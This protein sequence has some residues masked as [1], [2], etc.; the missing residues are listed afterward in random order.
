M[1]DIKQIRAHIASLI[2]MREHVPANHPFHADIASAIWSL[3]NID[4]AYD[5]VVEMRIIE[6]ILEDE[7]VV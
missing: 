5:A 1:L 4:K 3:R 7:E 2:E 6:N